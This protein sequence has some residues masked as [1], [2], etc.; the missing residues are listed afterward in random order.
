MYPAR[1]RRAARLA[2]EK[3]AARRNA[4]VVGVFGVTVALGSLIFASV[5]LAGPAL[6]RSLDQ[7]ARQAAAVASVGATAV[8]HATATRSAS[9]SPA[10]QSA[11]K[12]ASAKSPT[13]PSAPVKAP[14][15]P[16]KSAPA[17]LVCPRTGCAA[18]TCH[19]TNGVSASVWYKTHQ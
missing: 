1:S 13:A 15:A 9:M 3:A 10:A 18:V 7:Q 5:A 8:G 4:G 11:T 6:S 17:T 19:G 16:A 12:P 14:A 2:A